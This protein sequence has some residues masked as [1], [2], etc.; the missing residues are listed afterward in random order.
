M[1]TV[2]RIAMLQRLSEITWKTFW[3]RLW[4]WERLWELMRPI[5]VPDCF[6]DVCCWWSDSWRSLRLGSDWT[7]ALRS[8]LTFFARRNLLSML[9]ISSSFVLTKLASSSYQRPVLPSPA[10][11]L[12]SALSGFGTPFHLARALSASFGTLCGDMQSSVGHQ[13][14]VSASPPFSFT[15]WRHLRKDH[16]RLWPWHTPHLFSHWKI[17]W[18]PLHTVH[19]DYLRHIVNAID[20][21]LN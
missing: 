7:S 8:A 11:V 19:S 14:T 1:Y 6:W 10:L 16:S 3:Y 5:S 20:S 21:P 9:L 13:R 15:R 4:I 12:R 18:S 17:E 2:R